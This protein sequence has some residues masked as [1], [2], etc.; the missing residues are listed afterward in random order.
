MVPLAALDAVAGGFEAA[1]RRLFGFVEPELPLLIAGVEVEAVETKRGQSAGV[2]ELEPA[3]A[4]APRRA[5]PSSPTPC[6]HRWTAR[7]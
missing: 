3:R 7:R 1:H 2:L 4:T 6:A 5:A